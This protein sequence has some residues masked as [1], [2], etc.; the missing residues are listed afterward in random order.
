M[1]VR[2][3][4][5]STHAHLPA[6]PA[7]DGLTA[8]DAE[9]RVSGL[10]H[11]IAEIVAHM[12]FWQDWWHKRC[13]GKPAPLP[14]SAAFGWPP[15]KP[16]SWPELQSQFL[17]RQQQL[18]ALGDGDVSK[19]VTPPVEFPPLA[20]YTIEDALIHIVAHNAHH[21]GQVITLRQLLGVWPP[22][23]GSWTW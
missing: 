15:V 18:V 5:L 19:T 20:R 17:D 8:A 3:H 12:A 2:E 13:V 16:N 23:A 10:P 21:L 6:Q 7:L 14:A 4:L 1:N 11:S 22:P 9:R